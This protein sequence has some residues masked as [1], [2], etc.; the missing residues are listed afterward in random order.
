MPRRPVFH[1]EYDPPKWLRLAE[2]WR[3]AGRFA[4][5]LRA[6]EYYHDNALLVHGGS[7]YGVRL[8]FALSDW[9]DLGRLYPPARKALDRRRAQAATKGLG[10]PPDREMFHEALAIDEAR[11]D[12]R[13]SLELIDAFEAA[14]PDRLTDF[15][16][17]RV[18]RV[19]I[20]RGE[21]GGTPVLREGC[22]RTRRAARRRRPHPT[23]EALRRPRA[24]A[25]RPPV[26][27]DGHRPCP[28]RGARQAP[29]CR[30]T[31][32]PFKAVAAGVAMPQ[33]RVRNRHIKVSL[34]SPASRWERVQ[35]RHL[36]V[37]KP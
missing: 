3:D 8:S 5:A 14:C 30:P 9:V 12:D 10:P 11:R 20:A 2:E 4:D 15:S 34:R 1:G 17:H 19:L 27:R 16:D 23:G 28:G 18:R 22:R 6:H 29:E 26:L 31:R 13:A 7:Q 24:G 33:L 36:G 21:Y 25:P 32:S 35:K 37:P